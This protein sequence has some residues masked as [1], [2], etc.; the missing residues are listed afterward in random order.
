MLQTHKREDI[1]KEIFSE[2]LKVR[3]HLKT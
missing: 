1:N 2:N 3:G